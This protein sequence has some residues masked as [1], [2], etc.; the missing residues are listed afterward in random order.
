MTVTERRRQYRGL[1]Q[2]LR[3]LS[4]SLCFRSGIGAPRRGRGLRDRHAGG[5]RGLGH[6]AGRAGHRR[7]DADGTCGAGAPHRPGRTAAVDGGRGPRLRQRPE[8][9]EDG[10]GIGGGRGG[11]PDH[12]G[13][14]SPQGV[15][16]ARGRVR[17]P[18]GIRRQDARGGGGAVRPGAGDPGPDRRPADPGGRG[19]GGAR[20][21]LRGGG[22]GRRLLHRGP[23][24]RAGR[25]HPCHDCAAG[26]DGHDAAGTP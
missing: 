5:L 26:G 24:P 7:A 1:L 14:A 6:G 3:L 11:G 4:P 15:R 2:E 17:L 23:D 8:R 21:G 20:E 13:Y 9:H 18:G 19:A 16:H 22:S 10:G 25:R 12:R